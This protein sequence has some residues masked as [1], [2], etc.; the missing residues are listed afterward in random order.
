MALGSK[1]KTLFF[2]SEDW[3]ITG[4]MD[5]LDPLMLD[6]DTKDCWDLW[7]AKKDVLYSIDYTKDIIEIEEVPYSPFVAPVKP[8]I[9][10]T[11]SYSGTSKN[12]PLVLVKNLKNCPVDVGDTIFSEDWEY[13][14]NKNNK[15]GIINGVSSH[16]P[17]VRLTAA[18]LT[19]DMGVRLVQEANDWTEDILK[20][21]SE[22]YTVMLSGTISCI[23]TL[24]NKT[25]Y[26]VNVTPR[27]LAVS[28]YK[29]VEE[30]F[31]DVKDNELEMPTPRF[32]IGEKDA[33]AKEWIEATGDGC[34]VCGVDISVTERNIITWKSMLEQG[35]KGTKE[36]LVPLCPSCAYEHHGVN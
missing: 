18:N 1:G 26:V 19:D 33:T 4:L 36:V 9:G 29:E 25:G 20:D 30:V 35:T 13:Y 8:D 23:G 22:S 2:A 12:S 34:H 11:P 15:K 17:T 24:K 14:P 10:M 21:E 32:V 16:H 6:V 31:E 7:S 3:M 28:A 27:S 5:R